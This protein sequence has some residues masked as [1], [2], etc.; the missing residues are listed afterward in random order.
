[1][2]TSH[3]TGFNETYH[4]NFFYTHTSK[5]LTNLTNLTSTSIEEMVNLVNLVRFLR[6]C[7]CEKKKVKFII[8]NLTYLSGG[9][10]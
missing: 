7:V 2:K 8:S 1:M 5:N 4:P 9:W 3:S 6:V 10:L